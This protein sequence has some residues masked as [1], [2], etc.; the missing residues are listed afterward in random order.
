MFRTVD[1]CYCDNAVSTMHKTARPHMLQTIAMLDAATADQRAKLSAE[2]VAGPLEMLYEFGEMDA[3]GALDPSTKP[4]VL[5][6]RDTADFAVGN[7]Q[8][9]SK[10]S[11]ALV[12][13][14]LHTVIEGCEPSSGLR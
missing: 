10:W 9:T 6:G 7:G 3:A 5:F 14:S 4:V 8:H 2:D 1:S 13:A 11:E 12:G